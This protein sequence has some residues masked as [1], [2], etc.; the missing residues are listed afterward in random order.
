MLTQLANEMMTDEAKHATT[1]EVLEP[2]QKA[3]AAKKPMPA[4]PGGG[5]AKKPMPALPTQLTKQM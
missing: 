3:V 4:L 5:G 1:P 2:T